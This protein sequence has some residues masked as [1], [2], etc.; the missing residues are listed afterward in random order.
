M[1]I[2]KLLARSAAAFPEWAALA[3]GEQTIANYREFYEHAQCLASTLRTRFKLQPG[4]RVGFYCVNH[5]LY[6][7]AMYAVWI[8]GGVVVPINAKLH[9]REARYI[10]DNSGAVACWTDAGHSAATDG[11]EPG[12][13]ELD[14]DAIAAATKRPEQVLGIVPRKAW[15]WRRAAM[16]IW[17][18]CFIPVAPR[19]DPKA[20]C[21]ATET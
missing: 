12:C 6:L 3:D 16:T 7:E 21:S 5:P 15:P 14:I 13:P 9:P 17:P 4:D 20:P 18:G 19:V 1:N 10:L 8:A 2:A 11:A